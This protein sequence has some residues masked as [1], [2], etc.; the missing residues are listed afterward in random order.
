MAIRSYSRL[1]PLR[2]QQMSEKRRVPNMLRSAARAFSSMA[3]Q[4]EKCII[5]G[6]GPASW[7]AALYA[8]RA[9]LHPLVFPG[10]FSPELLPGGQLM[11][12]T[13]VENFPGFVK[14]TGPN[15]V[16][17]IRDQALNWGA[18]V[19]TDNGAET[20][21]DSVD[22]SDVVYHWQNVDRVD[23]TQGSP[24]TIWN[25]VGT[26]FRAH[27]V[28]IATGA[29]ANYLGLPSERKFYNR[30]VSACAVC[31]GA[32]P[33]FRNAAL[34]VVGGGDSAV[35]EATFL[36]K[37]ASTVYLVHRRDKLRA[38]KVMQQRLFDNKKIVV[39]WN[40]EVCDQYLEPF[41]LYTCAYILCTRL[42]KFLVVTS[43]V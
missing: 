2:I 38:S 41:H 20:K 40:R 28:I 21:V 16:S 12:T 31:D 9:N 30:G 27:T 5:I 36:T 17:S 35:E 15:L 43:Q 37:F 39:L 3:Q 26:E 33:R 6:S 42:Q 10:R 34:A 1:I 22:G 4:I 23:L 32:A 7:T 19:Q 25:D 11:T 8:A 13:D 24:F 18:R 14:V 29:S